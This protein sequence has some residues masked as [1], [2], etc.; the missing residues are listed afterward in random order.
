VLDKKLLV[1]RVDDGGE[2]CN[3]L[4]ML[5]QLLLLHKVSL[6]QRGDGL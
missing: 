2:T 5:A 3:A 6:S 4:L 1:H